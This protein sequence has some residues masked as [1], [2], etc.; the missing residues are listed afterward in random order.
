ML[1]HLRLLSLGLSARALAIVALKLIKEALK[2]K[3]GEEIV[4]TAVTEDD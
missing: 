4:I 1:A 2:V 3:E